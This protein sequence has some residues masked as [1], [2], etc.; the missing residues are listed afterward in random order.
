MKDPV[1]PLPP[2][3][4][5]I[6][7]ISFTLNPWSGG[8][9]GP[10]KTPLHW[11][12]WYGFGG[13]FSSHE[14]RSS[15]GRFRLTG[16]SGTETERHI[17]SDTRLKLSRDAGT[18]RE[19]DGALLLRFCAGGCFVVVVAVDPV[20]AKRGDTELL[21]REDEDEETEETDPLFPDEPKGL[22]WA[23]GCCGDVEVGEVREVSSESDEDFG[24]EEAVM[25]T[26]LRAQRLTCRLRF[27]ATPNR[28]PQISQTKA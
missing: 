24:G 9:P 15:I 1:V 19:G 23:S 12:G 3:P 16:A 7:P 2:C 4:N 28:R 25:F 18:H 11:L 8:N 17:S 5:G 6:L 20:V 26:G 21:P 10:G 14:S 13:T 22:P 27:E